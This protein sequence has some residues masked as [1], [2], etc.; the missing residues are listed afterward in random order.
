MFT[1]RAAPAIIV[2]FIDDYSNLGVVEELAPI[3]ATYGCHLSFALNTKLVTPADWT[4]IQA[5]QAAGTEI[6]AHTR[7]HSDLANNNVFSISYAGPAQTATMTVNQTAGTLSTFLNGS[8]TPDLVVPIQD[9][10]NSIQNMCATI[11]TNTNYTCQVQPNQLFFTPLN[12]ANVSLV[13]IKPGYMLTASSNYLAWEVEGAQAD[14]NANIPGYTVTSF[15]T[16]FSSSNA[17]VDTHIQNAGFLANRNGLTD[18]NLNIISGWSLSSLDVYNL[19]A[20]WIP[21]SYNPAQPAGSVGALVEGLGAQGG[22][23]T[24]YSHGLDEFSLA[25]WQQ[26]FQLLQSVGGTCMTMSQARTYIESHGKLAQDSTKRRWVESITLTPV[27]S[28]TQ[29]SPTQGAHG[30]Q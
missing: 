19:A 24:V 27:F 4:R 1:S 8:T 20:Y 13:N 22:V 11:A 7:S 5:L 9:K 26:F 25:S 3:A 10:W 6:V 12:L 18:V 16:P 14:I 23:M 29:S 2:P 15:A 21:N 28:N 17:T 30:L